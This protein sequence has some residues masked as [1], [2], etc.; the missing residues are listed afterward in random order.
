MNTRWHIGALSESQTLVYLQNA[1]IQ[2]NDAGQLAQY[3]DTDCNFHPD[4]S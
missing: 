3:F 2:K 1:V 4:T